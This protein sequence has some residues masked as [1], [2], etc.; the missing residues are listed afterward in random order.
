[1]NEI[2]RKS[3]RRV[4]FWSFKVYKTGFYCQLHGY[5]DIYLVIENALHGAYKTNNSH[6]K[7]CQIKIQSLFHY[8]RTSEGK[9]TAR[10]KYCCIFSQST[11]DC[12]E[13]GTLITK[14]QIPVMW[15]NHLK[16]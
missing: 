12:A 10:I 5:Y 13:F 9:A 3:F 2:F 11:V 14:T 8:N 4:S 15:L 6:I 16:N 7:F 1:M